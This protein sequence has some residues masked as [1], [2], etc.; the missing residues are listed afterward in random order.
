MTV[1][2]YSSFTYSY[3]DRARV[4]AASLRKHHPEWKIWAVL[5]DKEP[6]GLSLDWSEE[7]FDFVL[8]VGG[9]FGPDVERFLFGHDIVEAC[10]AVKGRAMQ[11]ILRAP[12]TE[13]VLYFDPDIAVFNRMDDLIELLDQHSIVLTPHQIDPDDPEQKQAIV[14]NEITSLHYGVFN[15]GFIAVRNDEEGRRFAAWWSDRLQDWCHDRLEM[16]LFTDQK[17]CNLIP[18]FFDNVKVLRDPGFNVASW[19]LSRRFLSFADDGRALANGS[20][21]R[22]YHFTKLGPVGATMTKR[23][24][25]GS[26]LVVELWWWYQNAIKNNRDPRIPARWWFYGTF[27]DGSPITRAMR[28]LYRDR[29]DLQRIFPE[30][31]QTGGEH[32]LQQWFAD[33]PHELARYS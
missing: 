16:G 5:V 19:N 24:A 7:D 20:L 21:L 8:T 15:L 31:F 23:Y 12:D 10:T 28:L 18:C 4:L 33:H 32:R 3:L 2:V 1:H 9:L 30:P 6:E 25:N 13:K 29:G 14:D 26:T 27:S 22:F 17:W 11:R